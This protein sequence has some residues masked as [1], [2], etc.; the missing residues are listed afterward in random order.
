MLDAWWT[1]I[2]VGILLLAAINA[3]ILLG[4]WYEYSASSKKHPWLTCTQVLEAKG[5]SARSSVILLHGFGGT[6]SDLRVLAERLADH[7]FRAI[8][9]AIPDQTST[10]FA[11]GRGR[12]SAADYA[13]WL[14]DLIRKETAACGQPPI[15]VGFSMGGA[16]ATLVAA[17]QAEAVAGLVLISPYFDLPEHIQ[18]VAGVTHWLRWI[19][20]V[21]P[22]AAKGQI[23]DPDGYRAYATGSYFVS[24]R[25]ALRLAEL[26]SIA[27]AKAGQIA[28]PTL[29]LAAEKDT[30][31]SF[32][33]TADL[34]C[35][36]DNVQLIVCNQ[37]NHIVTYDFD[38]ELVARQVMA[39]LTSLAPRQAGI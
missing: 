17:D 21:V 6:P 30:V 37:S 22:K 27:R 3:L 28:Q 24:L 2:A 9:P 35:R 20:P 16:L 4:A 1:V 13:D 14:R 34:F 38:R 12:V 15:L 19:L 31:A 11:Y 18:W 5:G 36:L 10:T 39:F 26:T 32:A 8:V 23:L 7:G 25:A 29:V 33:V